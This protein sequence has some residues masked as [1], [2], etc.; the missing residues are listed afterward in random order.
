M[1]QWYL[2]RNKYLTLTSH[3]KYPTTQTFPFDLN[4]ASYVLKEEVKEEKKVII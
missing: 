2:L 1:R 4:D 3:P